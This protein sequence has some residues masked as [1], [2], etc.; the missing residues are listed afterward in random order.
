MGC[1]YG[2]HMDDYLQNIVDVRKDVEG[3]NY[4]YRYCLY[5]NIRHLNVGV[6]E[7]ESGGDGDGGSEM[8]PSVVKRPRAIVPCTALAEPIQSWRTPT[9]CF[10]V[11]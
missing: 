1:A 8:A 11:G 10:L 9:L 2:G 4:Q 3:M 5:H 7:T 6:V